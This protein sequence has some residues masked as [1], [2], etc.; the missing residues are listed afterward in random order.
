MQCE[1]W[2]AA[3]TCFFRPVRVNLGILNNKLKIKIRS[4]RPRK[5]SLMYFTC[6]TNLWR[7]TPRKSCQ[8]DLFSWKR[9]VQTVFPASGDGVWKIIKPR[10]LKWTRG[11]PLGYPRVGWSRSATRQTVTRWKSHSFACFFPFIKRKQ[12]F[13]FY[14]D[15]DVNAKLFFR[16]RMLWDGLYV[17]TNTN[18]FRKFRNGKNTYYDVLQETNF[19]N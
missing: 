8:D 17:M 10:S 7:K 3:D 5:L 9:L 15:Y 1:K 2:Y 19:C 6:I 12:Y 4:C 14:C 18:R 11:L 13:H 16:F